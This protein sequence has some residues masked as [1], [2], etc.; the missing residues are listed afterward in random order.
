[1]PFRRISKISNAIRA[2][3]IAITFITGIKKKM[4]NAALAETHEPSPPKYNIDPPSIGVR[5]KAI[6]VRK[7]V[8]SPLLCI[9]NA[10]AH[11][12]MGKTTIP[13]SVSTRYSATGPAAAKTELLSKC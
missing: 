4:V 3:R 2:I 11:Q 6:E 8:T 9:Q 1:M 12:I 10:R 7:Q 13:Q 5:D